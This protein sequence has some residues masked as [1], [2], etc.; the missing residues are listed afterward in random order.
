MECEYGGVGNIRWL[1]EGDAE[2]VLADGQVALCRCGKPAGG[3]AFGKSAY[4]VWCSDCGPL[5]NSEDSDG[6]PQDQ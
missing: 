5:N 6:I 2:L 3:G 4:M 1:S